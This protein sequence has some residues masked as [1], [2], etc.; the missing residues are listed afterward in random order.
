M[1]RVPTRSSWA[2]LDTGDDGLLL[3]TTCVTPMALS[4][5]DTRRLA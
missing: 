4:K 5:G 3:D 1:I 2:L